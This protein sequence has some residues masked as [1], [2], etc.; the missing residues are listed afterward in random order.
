MRF[1][2][3]AGGA[4]AHHRHASAWLASADFGGHWRVVDYRFS[5]GEVGFGTSLAE[6]SVNGPFDG[7]L[8]RNTYR[9][10]GTY[11][12]NTALMKNFPLPRE[13]MKLQFRAEFYNLFNHPNLYVNG[14]TNDVSISSFKSK[15][16]QFGPGVTASFRDSRQIVPA[17]RLTF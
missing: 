17:L 14:N 12:Q 10:P 15:T 1:S 2:Y 3:R 6:I 7:T 5:G 4:S 8:S 16:G 9:A 11:Y 13:G